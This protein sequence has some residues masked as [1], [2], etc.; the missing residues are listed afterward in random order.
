MIPFFGAYSINPRCLGNRYR[1]YVDIMTGENCRQLR[2]LFTLS[3][4]GQFVHSIRGDGIGWKQRGKSLFYPAACV[5][6]LE[7][8]KIWCTIQVIIYPLFGLTFCCNFA[9]FNK[10]L[11]T[12]LLLLGVTW[13][14]SKGKRQLPI[15]WCTSPMM[16]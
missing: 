13:Q 11:S 2:L 4:I 14:G 7:N 15:N 8:M 3:Y 9:V 6:L 5:T 1:I 16:K 10:G 12:F